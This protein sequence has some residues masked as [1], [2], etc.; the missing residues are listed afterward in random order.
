MS[1]IFRPLT[2]LIALAVGT[3]VFVVAAVRYHTGFID[4]FAYQS[5]DST[6]Y[7]QIAQNVAAR[8]TFSQATEPPYEPDTWRTP[9]Y[10]LFLAFIMKLGGDSATAP[11]RI[12]R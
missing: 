3:H 6:E 5:L 1:R 12:T 8:G 9:G 10:P 7:Y 4:T 2:I 11:P